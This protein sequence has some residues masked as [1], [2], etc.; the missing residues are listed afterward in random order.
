MIVTWKSA[1]S[2]TLAPR[3]A[4]TPA[5][6]SSLVMR[7]ATRNGRALIGWHNPPKPWRPR[8]HTRRSRHRTDAGTSLLLP[9]SPSCRAAAPP[10]GGS[11][12]A[13]QEPF[14]EVVDSPDDRV[15]AVTLEDR[16]V[17]LA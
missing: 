13:R 6:P 17:G 9:V 14:V 5:P 16:M 2:S 15:H 8:G 7:V 12:P 11:G 10:P 3:S 1:G 4:S